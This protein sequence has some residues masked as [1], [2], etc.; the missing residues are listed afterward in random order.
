MDNKTVVAS[1]VLAV[2]LALTA[3]EQPE[4]PAEARLRPVKYFEISEA[5]A[6]RVRTFSGVS[7]SSQE[8]RS[9]FKVAGTIERLNVSLGD[10]LQPGQVIAELDPSTYQLQAQQAQADLARASAEERN[11]AANYQRIRG[12][13]ANNNASRNDLDSAR[14]AA[15]S[16]R[17]QV[18]AT[19][20]ALDLARLSVSYTELEATESC[21]VASV[22]AEAG[23]NVSAGQEI[24]MLTCGDSID[25]EISVPESLIAAFRTGL[26]AI[27]VFD[28]I[29]GKAYQG[30]VSEVGVAAI[31]GATFP[32]TI[33]IPD[34]H[35][36]LRSGLAAQVSLRFSEQRVESYILPAAAVGEDQK[37]RFVYLLAPSG[38]EG[39][40][41]VKRQPVAVG[42]LTASGIEINEGV[43]P[44]D[45]VVTAGVSVIRDGMSVKAY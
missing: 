7:K 23:E 28:A 12:L 19:R 3:C 32:V 34:T 6:D 8:T 4:Q 41:V 31:G 22:S 43:K 18:R 13:Y 29:R 14:A 20:K 33:S 38:N 2:A 21:A 26:S 37:G 15:E 39:E 30:V 17:A 25:V 44:G 35:N 27:V 11:S 42:S 1:V 36:E 16:S 40:A 9:S 24:V 45:K 10:N 5:A